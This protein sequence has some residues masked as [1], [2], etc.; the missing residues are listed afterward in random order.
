MNRDALSV[1]S[2]KELWLDVG[3][4]YYALRPGI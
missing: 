3:I 4:E 2:S 1:W